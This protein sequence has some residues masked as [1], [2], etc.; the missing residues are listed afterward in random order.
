MGVSSSARRTSARRGG[1]LKQ[2][3][4]ECHAQAT[5]ASIRWC[6]R[7]RDRRK[8]LYTSVAHTA[9]IK[10]WTEKESLPLLQFL[11]DHQTRPEF[12]LRF[13]WKVGSLAFWDNR[14]AMTF[15][16]T[17]TTASAGSCI[18]SPWKVTSRS[19]IEIMVVAAR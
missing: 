1:A 8:A 10:G 19:K 11:W 6:A 18:A 2:A 13:Q 5:Q 3:G 17:T 15:R 7:I 14:C 12:H 16:S 4:L 9:H